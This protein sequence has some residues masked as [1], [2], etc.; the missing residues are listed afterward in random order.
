MTLL[1]CHNPFQQAKSR[2]QSLLLFDSTKRR[3]IS[4][5]PRSVGISLHH[6]PKKQSSSPLPGTSRLHRIYD[7]DHLY[8]RS[9][10]PE[11]Y[12]Y[13]E[14]P[15][16]RDSD[17]PPLIQTDDDGGD[18]FRKF[19]NEM[20]QAFGPYSVEHPQMPTQFSRGATVAQHR[21]L[22][23]GTVFRQMRSSEDNAQSRRIS[24]VTHQWRSEALGK[25]ARLSTPA[26]RDSTIEG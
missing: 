3:R 17:A 25:E 4:E 12:D 24:F 15:P 20:L 18:H 11:R 10:N 8:S 5:V 23:G 6:P 9:W 21:S 2:K 14:T 13:I 22:R 7:R 1:I 16:S 26:L 19:N